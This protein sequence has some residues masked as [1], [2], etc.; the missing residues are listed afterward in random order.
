MTSRITRVL[1]LGRLG[2][3]GVELRH[4][5]SGTPWAVC[6]IELVETTVHGAEC[7]TSVGCEGW[8]TRAEAASALTPGTV[9]VCEG[10]L[11]R[12]KQGEQCWETVVT[13]FELLPCR[14]AHHEATKEVVHAN[15]M[16]PQ[17][18]FRD[19]RASWRTL[20]ASLH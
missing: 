2:K 20:M 15:T 16:T 14:F 13:G 19:A 7:T 11:K 18:A 1:L 17:V 4:A 6:T 10:R 5:N 12:Q 9:V 3:R 8:G